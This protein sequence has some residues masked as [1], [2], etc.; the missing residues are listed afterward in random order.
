M[1]RSTRSSSESSAIVPI[2]PWAFPE[3]Y[4]CCRLVPAVV[5]LVDFRLQKCLF[6]DASRQFQ[7]RGLHVP[8]CLWSAHRKDAALAGG[9][10]RVPRRR[11][12]WIHSAEGPGLGRICWRIPPSLRGNPFK[13]CT[14]DPRLAPPTCFATHALSHS[15]CVYVCVRAGG[16]GR[17]GRCVYVCVRACVRACVCVCGGAE[18]PMAPAA[19]ASC[20]GGPG[21][22]VMKCEPSYTCK[23]WSGVEDADIDAAADALSRG[24]PVGFPT[25]TVYGLGALSAHDAAVAKIFKAKGRPSDNPLIVH[26]ADGEAGLRLLSAAGDV[27]AEARALAQAFWPGPLS[28]CIRANKDNVCHS[29]RAGLDTVAVRVPD[30]PVALK[31][32]KALDRKMGQATGVAAPSANASGRPSPTEARHVLQDLGQGDKIAG[33]LD[34][35]AT[36][37]V[38]LESTVVGSALALPAWPALRPLSEGRVAFVCGSLD[39]PALVSCVPCADGDR[40]PQTAR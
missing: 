37:V 17:W 8:F 12:R 7:V 19:G 3:I 26:F 11:G 6:V 9:R 27:S 39:R 38:G 36:C 32:L 20:A 33:V 24:E 13:L 29:C 31:L 14:A 4:L 21:T 22:A 18:H 2:S 34:G 16:K 15:Q 30:H 40:G 10:D 5:R 28:I 25:E 1:H 23:L 35:G